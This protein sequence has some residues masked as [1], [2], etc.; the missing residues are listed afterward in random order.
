MRVHSKLV[1]ALRLVAVFA[2]SLEH[3]ALGP[4][5]I[6]DEGIC[7]SYVPLWYLLL[8]RH[9]MPQ[10][11]ELETGKDTPQSVVGGCLCRF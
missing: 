8:D 11:R 10:H 7:S 3:L 1:Q 4:V 5:P 9:S 6:I 2:L